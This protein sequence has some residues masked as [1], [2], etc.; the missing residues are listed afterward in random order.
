MLD[1]L[2]AMK[3]LIARAT[4]KLR[5]MVSDRFID[6]LLLM[7][8]LTFPSSGFSTVSTEGIT[9]LIVFITATLLK[10]KCSNVMFNART[11]Y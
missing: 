9:A 6:R 10:Y 7:G 2:N 8:A 5:R 11:V 3:Y 4:H 1:P